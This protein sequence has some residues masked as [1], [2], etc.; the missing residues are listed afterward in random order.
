M[1]FS[2]SIEDFEK[3][4][5][6]IVEEDD[7][8]QMFAIDFPFFEKHPKFTLISVPLYSN[9]MK[10][11]AMLLS[12]K[13]VYVCAPSMPLIDKKRY[14]D[15]MKEQFGESTVTAVFVLKSILKDYAREL[16][17]LR[18][19]MNQLDIEPVLED[20]EDSGR[21]LRKLTDR[22][23]ELVRL[24]IDLKEYEINEF[25]PTLISF[26]Y[27]LLNTEA[28]YLLER[29]RSHVYRISS[30]R[31]KFEMR[32]NR[33]LNDTMHRLT[34]IVTFLTIISIVV[35]V[36]GTIGA[37]FGIP[38]LSDAYF[39]GNAFILVLSL[40]ALT[41]LSVALGFLYWKSLGLKYKK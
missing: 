5:K 6:K 14:G 4:V 12:K 35:S 40:V 29:C 1:K 16:I 30:L 22:C 41:L 17:R 38:A 11:V 36:P 10:R 32:S 9:E 33:E 39:E 26:D 34:V 37:I 7:L 18:E 27:E 31:T 20:I 8:K 3:E 15:I 13:E 19:V 23:E 2:S 28:R 24:I 25:D 21:A